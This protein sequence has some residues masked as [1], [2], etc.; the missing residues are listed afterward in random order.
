[1]AFEETTLNRPDG[2]KLA[3]Y[4]MPAKGEAKAIVQINHGMAEHAGRYARFAQAL[5]QSGYHVIAH[6]HRGHGKTNA[7]GAALGHFGPRGSWQTV[8]EDVAAVRLYAQDIWGTL[9]V[10]IF[11]HSMGSIIAF[12]TILHE[13]NAYAAAALWNSGVENG[14]L[15]TVFR[16][17]LKTQRFFLGSDV[18]STLARKLTFDT[19][20]KAFAPN[21]TDFDWLSRDEAEVDKYITDPLCG[22]PVTIGL[23]LEVL[24]GIAR[25]SADKTLAHL[26]KSM[27]I[28]L[29]A[30]EDDPCSENG[31][32]VEN[33][34]KRMES[35][36]MT[37]VDYTLL[38]N[39]RHESLNEV[40]RDEV[41]TNFITLLDSHIIV[42]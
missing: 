31:K 35:V 23:W 1:M 30:G 22:F 38:L 2:A 11:G 12:N 27:P 40:N 36:G 34:A 37:T 41:T 5:T 4:Q 39:T 10:I 20:N 14:P 33:I 9:P 19:W 21:R 32:A 15:A 28:H 17:I 18:P 16:A 29:L 25:A 13:P 6:D 8:L 42:D 7:P 26:P 3:L 24:T